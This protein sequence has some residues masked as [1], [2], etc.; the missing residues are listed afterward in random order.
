M[1]KDS[2]IRTQ[3]QKIKTLERELLVLAMAMDDFKTSF[4]AEVLGVSP[5][6]VYQ[7]KHKAIKRVGMLLDKELRKKEQE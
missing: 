3:E 2:V 5:N 6:R 1:V 4:I 7:I